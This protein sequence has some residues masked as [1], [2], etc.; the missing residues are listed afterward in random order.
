MLFGGRLVDAEINKT[1]LLV[2][3]IIWLARSA[4]KMTLS[5]PLGIDVLCLAT[6]PSLKG[7]RA[8]WLDIGVFP[9]CVFMDQDE[10][11]FHKLTCEYSRLS[12]ASHSLLLLRAKHTKKNLANIT[13][14]QRITLIRSI[15]NQRE[16]IIPCM[17]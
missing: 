7:V 17:A 15:P 3:A 5:C 4:G 14:G 9:F 11:E 1:K 10:V 8:R 16:N 12:F 2:P 6:N 13:L